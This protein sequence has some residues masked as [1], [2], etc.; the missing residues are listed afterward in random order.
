[1]AISLEG[2]DSASVLDRI[3]IP[4]HIRQTIAERLAPGSTLIIAD[5]SI[6]S[7]ILP[8]GDDFLVL[9]KDELAWSKGRQAKYRPSRLA[10][11][12]DAKQATANKAKAKQGKVTA[13]RK[14]QRSAR[15]YSYDRPRRMRLFWRW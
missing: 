2:G 8:E 7:T 3:E 15:R 11:Q 12:D 5:T 14:V 1:M 4:G 6:N 9:A 13:T 10:K